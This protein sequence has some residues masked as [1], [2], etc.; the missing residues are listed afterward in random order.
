VEDA[1]LDDLRRRLADPKVGVRLAALDE[2]S[3]KVGGSVAGLCDDERVVP[4]L[5]GALSDSSR[6]VQRAAAR[7]L[8]PWIL[9]RP[10]LLGGILPDYATSVFDGTYTHVGLYDPAEGRVWLPRYAALK[11]HAALLADADTDRYFK[12][13]FYVSAQVPEH[14][15]DGAPADDWGA[16]VLSFICD[17]SYAQQRLIPAIDERKRR[18]NMREQARYGDAVV[19]FYERARLPYGFVVHHALSESGAGTR[20]ELGVC[21]CPAAPS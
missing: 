15:R 17:W 12:F 1:R 5:V 9:E 7:G 19:C 3:R 2:I 20:H 10:G 16:L 8:R 13:R 14:L 6:R 4:L 18:A 11:G 21:L